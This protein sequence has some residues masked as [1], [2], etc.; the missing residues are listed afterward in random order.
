MLNLIRRLI[1]AFL[2]DEAAAKRWLRAAGAGVAMVVLS[3]VQMAG[4]DTAQAIGVLKTWDWTDWAVRLG[5][6]LLFSSVHSPKSGASVP[7]KPPP[8]PAVNG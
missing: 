7:D 4:T 2:F 6:G 1:T 5:L 8:A 3:V